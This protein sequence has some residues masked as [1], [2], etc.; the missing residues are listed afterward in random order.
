MKQAAVERKVRAQKLADLAKKGEAPESEDEVEVDKGE[1]A[2]YLERAYKQEKF[3]KPRNLI[4][5][6][7]SLPVPEMEKLMLAN[8]PASDDDLRRLAEQRAAAVQDYLV[9]IGKVPA[10]RVFMLAPKLTAGE[11]KQ[12]DKARVKSSRADFSLK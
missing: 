5:F 9:D 6:A 7:K 3:P 8:A 10:E 2:K 1:Y 11:A 12:A 4:G